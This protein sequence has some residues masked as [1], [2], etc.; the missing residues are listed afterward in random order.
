MPSKKT[1]IISALVLVV[2]FM[3]YKKMKKGDSTISSPVSA[4]I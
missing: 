4:E 2:L 1:M 3:L